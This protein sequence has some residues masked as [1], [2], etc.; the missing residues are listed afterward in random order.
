MKKEKLRFIS[1][2]KTNYIASMKNQVNMGFSIMDM[3]DKELKL[4]EGAEKYMRH[5]KFHS[6]EEIDEK[7]IVKL[8]QTVHGCYE[9]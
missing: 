5:V 1:L 9:K 7:R 6:L 4:F 3:T 2:V 8:L